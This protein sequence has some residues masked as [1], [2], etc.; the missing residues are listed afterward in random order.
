[1]LHGCVRLESCSRAA[2]KRGVGA[3]VGLWKLVRVLLASESCHI[4]RSFVAEVG[5]E[6]ADC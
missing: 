5:A 4:H 6:P 2:A 3:A 1:M